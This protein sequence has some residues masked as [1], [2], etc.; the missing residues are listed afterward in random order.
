[1]STSATITGIY[2]KILQRDPTA[3]ETTTWVALLDSSN[4][5]QG[6]LITTLITST[7]GQTA[8]A[9]VIRVYQ[10]VFG[11]V[12]DAAG[13]NF[14][15]D[16]L[17]AGAS[18]L[19][20][21]QAFVNSPEFTARYGSLSPTGAITSGFVQELYQNILGR[22]PDAAGLQF[23]L[24][25]NITP[26]QML[27]QFANSSENIALTAGPISSFLTS[28]A[29][30]TQSYTG[31]L[32]PPA[33]PPPP[34]SGTTFTLTAGIDIIK[35]TEGPDTIIAGNSVTNGQ[36]SNN[37]GSG[38]L[39]NGAGGFDTLRIINE[40][41]A[42]LTPSIKGVERF[43]LQASGAN[44]TLDLINTVDAQQLW[45]F[46]GT[47]NVAVTNV[48]NEVVLGTQGAKGEYSVTFGG[49]V[50]FGGDLAI[51]AVGDSD[52]VLKVAGGSNLNKVSTL[53]VTSDTGKNTIEFD[54]GTALTTLNVSGTGATKLIDTLTEFNELVTVDSTKSTGAF[55]INLDDNNKDIT[56]T[57]GSGD[58]TLTTGNGK[59][60]I[61]TGVGKDTVTVGTGNNTITTGAGNDTV[62]AN[63]GGDQTISLGEGD[64][65]VVFGSKFTKEDVVTGGA[66]RDTISVD[67]IGTIDAI[68]EPALGDFEVLAFSDPT[69]GTLAVNATGANASKLPTS[70]NT[71]EFAELNGG[72]TLTGLQEAVTVSLAKTNVN[73]VTLTHAI[74]TQADSLNLVLPLKNS[75]QTILQLDVATTE[76]LNVNAVDK[77]SAYIIGNLVG[78][79][80]KT[81]NITGA[82]DVTVGS[83]TGALLRTIAAGT[84]SGDLNLQALAAIYEPGKA[85]TIT[86]GSGNDRVTDGGGADTVDVGAGNDFVQAGGG[87]DTITLGAGKDTVQYTA[88]AQSSGAKVDTITDFNVA[89]DTIVVDS[90]LFAFGAAQSGFVGT[91]ANFATAQGAITQADGKV[92]LVFQADTK[93]LWID[94]NDDGTLNANDMQIVLS[95]VSSISTTQAAAALKIQDL[96]G[97]TAPTIDLL[98]ASDSGVSSTDDITNVLNVDLKVTF[99]TGVLARDAV[100]GDILTVAGVAAPALTA[101]DIAAGFVTVNRTLTANSVNSL[102]AFITDAAG[103]QGV[104][105][106]VLAVTHDG[107][108]PTQLVAID[109]PDAFDTGASSTDNITSAN[110]VTLVFDLPA[111]G[112][113]VG[114]VLSVTGTAAPFTHTITAAD[115]ALGEVAFA[116]KALVANSTNNV[117]ATITDIA[118]NISG[119]V[120]LNIVQDS[121]A[122]AIATFA[123]LT[124][125][126]AG[127]GTSGTATDLW[128]NDNTLAFKFTT[129]NGVKAELL[130]NGVTIETVATTAGASTTFAPTAAL[131]DGSYNFAV[132]LTDLAGNTSTSLASTVKVDTTATL[133]TA[134]DLVAAFDTGSS[135]SDNITKLTN[136]DITVDTSGIDVGGTVKLTGGFADVTLA[137]AGAT[138][139]FSAYQLKAD[140]VNNLTV[141]GLDPANNTVTSTA[142]AVT[143]DSTAPV[144]GT[145]AG[146]GGTLTDLALT[147][148]ITIGFGTE[149]DIST[150]T[151]SD[152]VVGGVA[153][154]ADISTLTFTGLNGAGTAATGVSFVY[155]AQD[156]K[157]GNATFDIAAGSF[158]DLA[159]NLNTTAATQAVQVVDTVNPTATSFTSGAAANNVVITFSE[160]VTLVN[161]SGF[162]L[163]VNGLAVVPN[164]A[165]LSAANQVTLVTAFDITAGDTVDIGI[166]AGAVT[167]VPGNLIAVVGILDNPAAVLAV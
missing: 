4:A 51:A 59:S 107:T 55:T 67:V 142:L 74:D 39:I 30:G 96:L 92:D 47:K 119:A 84:S 112:V 162:S 151:K 111:T 105:S 13:L 153:V 33:P 120:G 121:T 62:T 124:T 63:Q 40:D 28:A 78:T 145:F 3:A 53:N 116:G 68:D 110:P 118:G 22:A 89:E 32:F 135:N 127:V 139:T 82:A 9:S 147:K 149:V 148:T 58:T 80:L 160:N 5:T 101:A 86:T 102:T 18:P 21:A 49:K 24:S 54:A 15:T 91:F 48:V 128:T 7:E 16:A 17:N 64:D 43:D 132:K 126:S 157:A 104:T 34:P 159:G 6:D 71:F 42:P 100:A 137:V 77:D 133:A 26:A 138:T 144:K 31:S 83:A 163:S 167:D 134:P 52:I 161:T 27:T 72:L 155:T 123:T 158:A 122:P 25:T 50:D 140:Q 165:T 97:P 19:V 98:A 69:S 114:D 99:Q 12:P 125:D 35:G 88:L 41:G 8:V 90:S 36:S 113:V 154:A 70:I 131:A 1:M 79:D 117:S 75:T 143:Q 108:A 44:L 76:T 106:A 103:N 166:A 85:V 156:N 130:Q 81:I 152:I 164:S 146:N 150:F 60:T 14:F 109:L 11:R 38:D 56:F 136:V 65:T 115:I 66:G 129:E 37:L 61:T 57:G 45:A 20:V 93:T 29:L 46:N 94:L 87:A 73:T 95:S 141:V 10:A 23:W 2:T